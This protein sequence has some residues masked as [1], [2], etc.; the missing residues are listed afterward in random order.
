M[1]KTH[2]HTHTH[3][4]SMSLCLHLSFRA[5]SSL[6][7]V[8]GFFFKKKT[9]TFQL[10]FINKHKR[11]HTQRCCKEISEITPFT[12]YFYILVAVYL[13]MGL[14]PI[15]CVP[16]REHLL[17]FVRHGECGAIHFVF[18][19]RFKVIDVH[20]IWVSFLRRRKKKYTF[21]KR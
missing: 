15:L 13:A 3:T 4:L 18:A 9:Y 2:T 12:L 11:T 6:N 8:R 7:I 14:T 17:I 21:F 16:V 19:Q 5:P 10:S 1:L 20:C